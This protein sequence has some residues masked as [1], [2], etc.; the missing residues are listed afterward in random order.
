MVEILHLN[1]AKVRINTDAGTFMELYEKFSFRVPGFMHMPAYKMGAWDGY[2]R[3]LDNRSQTAPKGLVPAIINACGERGYQ[4][5]ID[6]IIKQQFSQKVHYDFNDLQL[7]FEPRDFQASAIETA[8]RKKRQIILSS[9]GS[10]KSLIIYMLIRFIL[11]ALEEHQKILL[12]VPSISL[13]EQMFADFEN[14]AKQADFDV[15]SNVHKIFGGQ[16]KQSDKRVFVSTWQSLQKSPKS[17]FEQF[18]A[19]IG[20]EVHTFAAK[21]CTGIMDRCVNAF[22]RFGL[23]GTLNDAKTHEMAL[24]GLFGP[25]TRVSST[26]DLMDKGILSKLKIKGIVLKHP[27]DMCQLT[28]TYKYQD[29]VSYLVQYKPRNEFISKLAVSREGN[30]LVLFQFVDKHGKPLEEMISNMA[31]DKKQVHLVYGGT[32]SDQREQVRQICETHNDVIIVASYGVFS[33]GVSINNLHNIVFASPTKSKIRVLQSIG[34]GLRLHGDKD[35]A[36]LY[37]IADDLR[38]A[39]KKKNYTLDHFISRYET[40]TK[41]NFDIDIKEVE[42]RSSRNVI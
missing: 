14:Y 33:T 7:P 34:R 26:K 18:G 40:Y 9:T 8:L 31:G 1:E 30:T 21:V 41:E 6:D 32:D 10:G 19:V 23:T 37:D 38:G 24:T 20:D 2:I 27:E 25:V 15:P 36:T 29:E 5:Q 12:I 42:L 16:D 11:D 3:L 4:V 22:F 17:Y 13:V 35:Y 39:R 28:G